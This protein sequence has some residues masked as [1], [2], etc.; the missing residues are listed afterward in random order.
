MRVSSVRIVL[1]SSVIGY[2]TTNEKNRVWVHS[3]QLTR[4]RPIYEI[5]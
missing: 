2:D 5:M 3:L 1:M 4:P